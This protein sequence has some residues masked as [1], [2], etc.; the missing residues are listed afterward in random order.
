VVVGCLAAETETGEG[1]GGGTVENTVVTPA[2]RTE[3]SVTK[4]GAK[5]L[6]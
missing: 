4:R 1:V 3:D 2:A 6:R 5:A